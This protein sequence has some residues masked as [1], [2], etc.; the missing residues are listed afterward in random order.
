MNLGLANVLNLGSLGVQAEAVI[1]A[2]LASGSLNVP[3]NDVRN[4]LAA[5]VNMQQQVV[6][7]SSEKLGLA[8]SLYQSAEKQVRS[9]S[10]HSSM[11]MCHRCC[12]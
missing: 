7:L 6:T 3:S 11:C 4:S 8:K 12:H 5:A 1:N 2:A 9:L 10:T